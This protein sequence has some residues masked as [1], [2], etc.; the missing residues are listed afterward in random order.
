[1]NQKRAG[2][3]EEHTP[4]SKGCYVPHSTTS[5]HADVQ[6]AAPN[7]RFFFND[8]IHRIKSHGSLIW[9]AGVHVAQCSEKNLLCS[10]QGALIILKEILA[11]ERQE[12]R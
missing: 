6:M 3:L 4:F 10:K 1:M 9:F 8:A 2:S 5:R 7:V 12:L 11:I